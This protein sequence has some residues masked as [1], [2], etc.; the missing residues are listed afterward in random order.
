MSNTISF[1]ERVGRDA[2][3]RHATNAQLA[4]MMRQERIAPSAQEAILHRDRSVLDALL[5]APVEIHCAN[6]FKTPKTAPPSKKPEKPAKA[7]T[8]K[9]SKPA[10]KTPAKKPSKPKKR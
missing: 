10:K 2:A 6:F 4:A 5:D 7:P 9:P 3:L 8:K 1:L